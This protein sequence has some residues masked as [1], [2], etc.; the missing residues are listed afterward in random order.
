M[1]FREEDHAGKVPF[2]FHHTKGTCYQD[3]FTID[4]DFDHLAEVVSVM[5]S[6]CIVTPFPPS[7][8]SVCF[9]SKSLCTATLK[10]LGVMLYFSEGGVL[11]KLFG[12]LW[13]RTF[14]SLNQS[15]HYLIR[16]LLIAVWT[17]G[18]LFY[19]M[20]H[21]GLPPLLV[22]NLPLQQWEAWLQHPSSFT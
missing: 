2:S 7:F 8:H 6:H 21:F 16:S 4:V 20:G 18:Y 14:D 11:H 10:D 1:G 9:G 5:F 22:C 13:H 15:D 19:I 17:H 3:D 12:I